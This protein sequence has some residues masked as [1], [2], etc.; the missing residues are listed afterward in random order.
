LFSLFHFILFYFIYIILYL[1]YIFYIFICYFLFHLFDIFIFYY[2]EVAGPDTGGVVVSMYAVKLALG[3]GEISP[4]CSTNIALTDPR[5]FSIILTV[6]ISSELRV[7]APAL[8]ARMLRCNDADAAVLSHL[9][10]NSIAWETLPVERNPAPYTP[11]FPVGTLVA[12]SELFGANP[13]S[14]PLSP[15]DCDAAFSLVNSSIF[16][17]GVSADLCAASIAYQQFNATYSPA[18]YRIP[19]QTLSTNVLIINGDADPQTPLFGA[20][21]E[22]KTLHPLSSSS[23]N[24]YQFVMKDVAHQTISVS[25]LQNT[26]PSL[27]PSTTCTQLMLISLME[28]NGSVDAMDTSCLDELALSDWLG[29]TP[30]VQASSLVLFGTSDFWD[31]DL[32]QKK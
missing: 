32:E 8:V 5:I 20:L 29:V 17:L 19:P 6:M 15:Q 25:F 28:N 12:A 22:Y 24:V 10:R 2:V 23:N 14:L 1:F 13:L 7:L 21:Q 18:F 4:N 9:V 11:G 31:G 3:N 30:R 26:P 16:A 27:P